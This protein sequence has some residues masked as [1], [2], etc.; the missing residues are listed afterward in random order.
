MKIKSII[1]SI[2][3]LILNANASLH[4]FSFSG[5]VD[6]VDQNENNTLGIIDSGDLFSG[7]F[8]YSD[9]DDRD[10]RVGIGNYSQEATLNLTLGS[11]QIEYDGYIYIRVWNDLISRDGFDFAVDDQFEDWNMGWYGFELIDST[12]TTYSDE[13]LPSSFSASDFNNPAFRL[14][15]STIST[16]D[17][18]SVNMT[19]Q[20]ISPIPEPSTISMLG[21]ASGIIWTIRRKTNRT[22]SWTLL[23]QRLLIRSKFDSQ[24]GQD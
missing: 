9:I 3:V 15:G 17:Q 8:S 13:S 1:V 24:A 10:S 11:K 7:T 22:R 5:V 18:F 16:G 2:F 14:D 4:S 6:T 20:N 19:V 23:G 12:Q 21:L